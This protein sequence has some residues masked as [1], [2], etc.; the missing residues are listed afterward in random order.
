MLEETPPCQGDC[1]D[2]AS[3]PFCSQRRL[4][5]HSEDEARE[6]YEVDHEWIPDGTYDSE[7]DYDPVGNLEAEVTLQ[8]NLR[9]LLRAA[10]EARYFPIAEY[11]VSCLDDNGWLDTDIPNIAAELNVPVDDVQR[12]LHALQSLDPPGIGARDLRECLLIQLEFLAEEGQGN[13]LA[14]RMVR[15][16]F[17]DI[18]NRRFA[19]IARGLGVTQ[20]KVKQTILYIRTQLNPYPASQFRPP[21]VYKPSSSRAAVRPDVIIRR[22]EFGYDVE[23][24]GADPHIL[25][26]NPTYLSRY[27]AIRQ[28]SARVAE[29]ERKHVTE[30]VERAEL[31]IRNI[32]QRRKTLRLITKCI[33][34]CQQGFL[35]TGS[36]AYVRPLTRTRVAEMLKMHE[37]TVSRAT[38]NKYVQLP[39][40]EVVPFDLF[41]N[42]SLSIKT[43][44]EDIIAHEDPSR[45]LS[46]QQI[47][48]VLR[49]RG[50]E[51]ARRTVVKYR[52]SQK[53]LSSNRRRR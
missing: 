43:A 3:C 41:F 20:E 18:V 33:I 19:K 24:T 47:A 28:G 53:L 27:S 23:I 40:Q 11:M 12:V 52:E 16:H 29:D 8:D 44:I 26:V 49:E 35:E 37:S 14:E 46:D 31:F 9:S 36:R 48:D 6:V 5:V 15:N 21:W 38:A 32:N 34:E 50:V 10:L 13:P 42:S 1:V 25:G 51:V 45:P 17:Q 7:D 2:P 4:A 30:Y 39:N 22:T